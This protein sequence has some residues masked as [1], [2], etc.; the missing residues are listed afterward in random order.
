M[1]VVTQPQYALVQGEDVLVEIPIIIDNVAP[2]L[3]NCTDIFASIRSG[4]ATPTVEFSLNPTSGENALE[5]DN[6][7]T[8]LIKLPLKRADTK[9]LPTGTLF[10]DVIL[11]FPDTNFPDGKHKEI[12]G[13]RIGIIREGKLKDK[14]I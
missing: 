10:C 11:E 7:Q 3:T 13:I 8:N 12:T 14:D 9:N 1:P 4:T 6:T 2:D 5:V